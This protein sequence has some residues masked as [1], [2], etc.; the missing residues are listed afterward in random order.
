MPATYL[1]STETA[2]VVRKLLKAAFPTC[3][4]RVTTNRGSMVSSINVKWTDGPTVKR[5]EEITDPF[6]AGSF[7]GMTDSYEYRRE[8]K[9]TVGG[10]EYEPGCKYVHT[11]R[12]ISPALAL[13][14]VAQVATY[15]GGVEVV[16]EVASNKYGDGYTL[17]PESMF[18]TPV[19]P[20]LSGHYYD[21]RSQIHRAAEDRTAFTR[22]G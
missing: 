15:W 1:H 9:V 8:K 7:D 20:D 16:P 5:V 12:A 4:F 22:E 13:K 17:V 14:C 21:W 6:V 11:S 3:T 10:V 2:A 18:Y 19:R